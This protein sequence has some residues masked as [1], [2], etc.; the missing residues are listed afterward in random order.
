MC[1]LDK[2]GTKVP[3]YPQNKKGS[4]PQKSWIKCAYT[5]RYPLFFAKIDPKGDIWS[6]LKIEQPFW[7]ECQKLQKLEKG[8]WHR[9]WRQFV[10]KIL[11]CQKTR[12]DIDKWCENVLK[13]V[14]V[15]HTNW[16]VYDK[17]LGRREWCIW[18]LSSVARI[19]ILLTV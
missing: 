11:N 1:I 18:N 12:P 14:H 19:L 6:T 5:P 8:Y 7:I 16:C 3:G 10:N 13:Y 2:T 4:Y 9:K 15:I 17:S